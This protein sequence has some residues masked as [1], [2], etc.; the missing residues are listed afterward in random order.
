MP[1]GR[2]L[3]YIVTI[4]QAVAA[5]S[6]A[7]TGHTASAVFWSGIVIANIGFLMLRQ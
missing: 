5:L 6:Y 3:V 1:D 7:F 4:I 2:L